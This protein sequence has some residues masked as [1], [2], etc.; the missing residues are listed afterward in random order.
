M[1]LNTQSHTQ[2]IYVFRIPDANE[3]FKLPP[4]TSEGYIIGRADAQSAFP[5]DIDLAPYNGRD[6]GVSRR[7]AALTIYGNELHI[8]DLDSVNGT[9]VNSKR[10]VADAPYALRSGDRILLGDFEMIYEQQLV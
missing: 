5:P 2:I 10:L 3:S 9:F 6:R 7:H 4:I 8:V 1:T